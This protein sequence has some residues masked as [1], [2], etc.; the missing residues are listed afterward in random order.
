[1]YQNSDRLHSAE[2]NMGQIAADEK[3][4]VGK[5]RDFMYSYFPVLVDYFN[6]VVLVLR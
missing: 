1:M 4:V 2:W 3:R 6:F 5:D